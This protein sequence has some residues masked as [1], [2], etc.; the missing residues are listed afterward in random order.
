MCIRTDEIAGPAG[1]GKS[2][3][4]LQTAAYARESGWIVLYVPRG[5]SHSTVLQEGQ[6]GIDRIAAEWIKSNTEYHYHSPSL[7][8]HQST[9]A[10]NLLSTLLSVNETHLQSIIST[11]Q[12][13]SS[14][15]GTTLAE[16]CRAGIKTST[17]TGATST[18]VEVLEGV[19]GAL[20]SQKEVPVLLAIDEIQALFCKSEVRTPDY[21]ILESYHLSTPKLALDFLTGKKSFVSTLP[22]PSFSFNL[23]FFLS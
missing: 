23:L 14:Q 3:L 13:G 12:I 9:L 10:S 4:L 16:V 18:S 8:F 5:K 22:L 11:T 7:S 17:Q 2:T 19:L 21:K 6:V 20:A 15:S 1:S